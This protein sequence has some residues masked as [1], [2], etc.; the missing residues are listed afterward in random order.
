[1]LK[2]VIGLGDNQLLNVYQ[3]PFVN[4][5]KIPIYNGTGALEYFI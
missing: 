3:Q 5:I 2:M 1:M 4:F